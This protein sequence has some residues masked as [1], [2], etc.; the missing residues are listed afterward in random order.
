MQIQKDAVAAIHYVLRDKEGKVLD[1]NDERNPLFYLHGHGNLVPGL[2]KALL[3]K[4]AGDEF[5]VVI[6]PEDGYGAYDESRVFEVQKTDLGAGVVPQKGL[7]LRMQGPKGMT[8]PVTILKV[9][10]RTVLMD[11]NHQLAGKDLHFSIVVGKVRKA[12]K[13]EV[14][15]GHAHSPGAHAHGH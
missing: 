3:G 12:K 14:A 9:K 5:E 15:H 10:L 11:G 13:E 1:Q 2:E 6:S 4:S 8:I 7:V